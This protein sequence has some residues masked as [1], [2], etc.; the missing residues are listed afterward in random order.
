MNDNSQDI[1][2][3]LGRIERGET[4]ARSELFRRVE[5][6]LRVIGRA[7]LRQERPDHSIEATMLV[8]DAFM[9]LVG[10]TPLQDRTHFYRAAARAMRHI[11]IDHARQHD[12]RPQGHREVVEPNELF[13]SPL[14]T[15]LLALDEALKKLANLDSRQ[16]E[17]VELHHFGGRTMDETAEILGVSRS[18]IKNDWAFAKAWLHRELTRGDKF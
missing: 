9:R 7:Y 17:V 15:D 10:N 5:E 13:T 3:I 16:V 11:L 4:E 6:E 14:S 1:T 2:T 12:R 18:T 8:D